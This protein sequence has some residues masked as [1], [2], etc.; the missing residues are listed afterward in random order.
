MELSVVMPALDAE[1]HI[2]E[3]LAALERQDYAG[4]WELVV[5]DNGS[6]DGTRTAVERWLDRLPVRIVDASARRGCGPARNQA[7]GH[8]RSDA[9]AFCDADDVVDPG[10]LTAH[11]RALEHA[12]VS[13]GAIVFFEEHP[14]AVPDVPLRAPTLL[15]WL[16]Y[17]QG[18]NCAVRRDAYDA[19]GGF[20]E[21]NPFAEDVE[22]SWA[23]QLHGFTL[24]YTP[25]AI[26]FKRARHGSWDRFVQSYRYGTCDVDLYRRYRAQGATR[27]PARSTA[28]TYLGLLGRLPALGDDAV[29]DRWLRQA[30]RRAGRVVGSV[31]ERT[32]LP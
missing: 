17:A 6:T 20:N 1:E 28:R 3:Q 9:L 11:A 10:W 26:V 24:G 29:R 22:F 8:A 14:P 30:G 18:A 16:P 27:P 4:S 12:A 23:A 25:D 15:G 21:A 7:I 32:F 5:A 13:A 19:V 31:K 2:E